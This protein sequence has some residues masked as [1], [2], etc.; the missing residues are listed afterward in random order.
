MKGKVGVVGYGYWGPRLV[1]NF[2]EEIGVENVVVSDLSDEKLT[3]VSKHYPTMPTT[4][5]YRDFLRDSEIQAVI[6]AT[7]T[8]SHFEIAHQSLQA[9]KHV[10]VEKPMVESSEEAV[11]LVEEA[12]RR[13]LVLMVDHTFIYTDAVR[14][15][16]D[17]VAG[18]KLGEIYY[19]DSVRVN[20]GLFQHDVNVLWDLAV[21]DLSIMEYLLKD[22]PVAVSATGMSHIPGQPE[23]VAYLTLFF[24]GSLI[25]HIHV[26]WL[27]PV[28][29]R[30]TLIGGSRQMVVYDDLTPSEKVRVYDKGVI[31]EDDPNSIYQMLVGYRTGDMLAPKLELTEALRVETQHFLNCIQGREKCLT[32]GEAGFRVIEVL[33]AAEISLK[34]RGKVVEL[35]KRG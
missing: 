22:K 9:G 12:E 2:V 28:K 7:P 3:A 30:R 19:Y 6:I 14:K 13:K 1:R 35:K 29:I 17:L 27:A 16:H 5:D 4:K 25:G 33:E 20:L 10:L 23:D 11:R 34:N 18:Q 24:E 8:S 26:N 31:L 21:H 15:I 32:D